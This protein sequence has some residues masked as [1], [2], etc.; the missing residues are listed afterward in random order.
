MTIAI[1]CRRCGNIDPNYPA[2]RAT[3]NEL[4]A[5]CEPREAGIETEVTPG[6]VPAPAGTSLGFT[7]DDVVSRLDILVEQNEIMIT[8]SKNR[9][10]QFQEMIEKFMPMLE[11]FSKSMDQSPINPEN[12]TI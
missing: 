1:R 3:G 12:F 8:S 7:L 6:P 4:C 10:S 11:K 2:S 9:D 5:T